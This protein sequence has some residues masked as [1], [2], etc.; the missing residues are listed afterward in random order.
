MVISDEMIAQIR[1]APTDTPEWFEPGLSNAWKNLFPITPISI[2]TGNLALDHLAWAQMPNP[3][4]R[5]II[6]AP[7]SVLGGSRDFEQAK[8]VVS[9]AL[10]RRIKVARS[11]KKDCGFQRVGLSTH[12]EPS[13]I[14][15]G[16]NPSSNQEM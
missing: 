6:D 11:G 3:W 9:H 4:W 1:A 10:L 5:F 15:A 13:Y 14:E 8:E 2:K 16:P 12:G 7:P